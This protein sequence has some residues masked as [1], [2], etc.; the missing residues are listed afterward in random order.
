MSFSI[1]LLNFVQ[2]GTSAAEIWR[3]IDFQDGSRQ[4]CSACFGAMADH[5][6]S[7][8]CGL[9][10]DLKSL[11]R[12]IN[13]SGDMAMYII[14]AFWLETAYFRPFLASFCGI[15]PHMTS[16][17]LLTPKGLF[18]GNTSF[19]P[20]SVRI[21]ASVRPGRMIKKRTIT[22]KSQKC[23]ISPIWGKAPLDRFNPKVARWV[24]SAT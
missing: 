12:R 18:S 19:E 6:R 4:P 16:P 13:S 9:N 20:F 14:L 15:F 1:R 7:A 10:S 21:C 8:F 24:M 11:V 17:I 5:P 3:N 2:I 22:K 23:Y